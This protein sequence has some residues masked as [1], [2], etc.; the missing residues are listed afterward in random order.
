MRWCAKSDCLCADSWRKCFNVKF[1]N[2]DISLCTILSQFYRVKFFLC[3][4]CMYLCTL[5]YIYVI[6]VHLIYFMYIKC[7]MDFSY[8]YIWYIPGVAKPSPGMILIREYTCLYVVALN[9]G[10][11]SPCVIPLPLTD[12]IVNWF[13][14]S[15][16]ESCHTCPSNSTNFNKW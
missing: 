16:K 14:K 3:Y 13:S 1:H 4:E 12:H 6:T 5:I 2:I 8:R 11:M 7:Y 10:D 9:I 15:I